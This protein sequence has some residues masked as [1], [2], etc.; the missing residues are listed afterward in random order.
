[1]SPFR[2]VVLALLAALLVSV[3]VLDKVA[4]TDCGDADRQVEDGLV[5]LADASYTKVLEDDPGSQCSA[6]GLQQVARAR[7]DRAERIFATKAGDEAT[8]AYVALLASEP[9]EPGFT[10]AVDGLA[11]L[12]KA[13]GDGAA[14]T[15]ATCCVQ[16]PDP[17]GGGRP[18]EGGPTDGGG[19][20]EP[21][22]G[23]PTDDGP[24]DEDPTDDGP[25][26][27]GPPGGKP[28]GVDPAGD[29]P[30]GASRCRKG[31]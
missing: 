25:T 30:G 13:G 17:G 3:A 16:C 22:G 19:G 11:L 27:E 21:T 18:T 9:P 15:A 6:A 24:S 14:E 4:P 7:C 1:M 5:K 8:K 20:G 23:G 29:G 2:V 26:D 12:A 31:R 10:C 28:A